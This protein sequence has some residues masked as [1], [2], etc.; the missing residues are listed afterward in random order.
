MP[1][2]DLRTSPKYSDS[3]EIIVVNNASTDRTAEIAASYPGVQVVHEPRK[4]IVWARRAGYLKSSGEL[5]ANV[6]SDTILTPNWL[7]TVF[8]E[9][10]KNPNLVGLSGPFKYYDL[11]KLTSRMINFFY[12]LAYGLYLLNRFVLRKGSMLQGGNF[13]VTRAGLEKIGGYDTSIEFY[14]EDTNIARRL[15]E[16]GDVKFTSKLPMH[17]SGRRLAEEGPLTMAIKY[18]RNYFWMTFF[19]KPKDNTYI[20]HRPQ[21]SGQPT[22]QIKRTKR[23]ILFGV[24]IASITFIIL[25]GGAFATYLIGKQII[26]SDFSINEAKAATLKWEK[27]ISA[28]IVTFS[29]KTKAQ[30][31]NTIREIKE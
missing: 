15:H 31:Q 28:D 10:S 17:S 12:K 25:A 16:I 27:R 8:R 14:G 13:I 7:D 19:K 9:F 3:V 26:A 24:C 20:D 11:P 1:W 30:I 23:E 5:I 4:G 29:H 22:R 6:D 21:D 18:T 2:F